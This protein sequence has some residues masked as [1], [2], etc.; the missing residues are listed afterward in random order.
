MMKMTKTAIS[1]LLLALLFTSHSR[2]AL[3]I[4]GTVR[5]FNDSHPD[6]ESTISGLR[7]G[8]V[9]STLAADKDPDY[10]GPGGAGAGGDITSAGT[11][12]EW[13]TDVAG[14]N[15]SAPLTLTLN[16]TS[17]GSGVFRFQDNAFF[18]IDGQLFGNQ[19]RVHNFHF[20]YE[21]HSAFTYQGGEVFN[22][23]GDDDVWLF[24]DDQLVVDLGGVHAAVS[25]SVSLD[26]LGLTLGQDYDFDLF[27]AERHTVASN[28][29]METSILLD[30]TIP[31]PVPEP[32]TFVVWSLVGCVCGCRCL[33]E[34]EANVGNVLPV[35]R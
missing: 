7:T 8:L 33:A 4:T 16:E 31:A 23:T 12:D 9:N 10:I 26:T 30:S 1:V 15:V 21:I 13:Y 29:E 14:V 3:V 5:D 35:L 28:F 19:G 6:F 18:P 2:G 17:P 32:T 24:I 34:T 25:G 11:F 27:F 22:F 20:T